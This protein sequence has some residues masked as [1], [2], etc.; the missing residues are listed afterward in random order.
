MHRKYT[1]LAWIH[2]GGTQQG[3][4]WFKSSWKIFQPKLIVVNMAR[5]PTL[6]CTSL[7]NKLLVQVLRRVVSLAS[8]LAFCSTCIHQ[9]MLASCEPH[10]HVWLPSV[11][12]SPS[13]LGMKVTTCQGKIS[14]MTFLFNLD[15]IRDQTHNS[16][17]WYKKNGEQQWDRQYILYLKY[18][19]HLLRT[20]EDE[21]SDSLSDSSILKAN[22][23]NSSSTCA[24][25]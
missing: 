20:T 5:W 6:Y 12:T 9:I 4:V 17:S 7:R 2:R 18:W 15:R 3:L 1:V 14:L 21:Y 19:C 23:W 13:F 16:W 8:A 24:T 25:C 10:F 11:S 22:V